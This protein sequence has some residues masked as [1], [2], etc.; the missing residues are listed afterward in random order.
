MAFKIA[1][2]VGGREDGSGTTVTKVSFKASIGGR[3]CISD[4]TEVYC[5]RW[6]AQG[7]AGF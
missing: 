6:L 7:I 3:E 2:G 1:D 5:S 4:Y